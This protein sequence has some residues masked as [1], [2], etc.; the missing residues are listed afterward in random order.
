MVFVT[1]TDPFIASPPDKNV[2]VGDDMAS[3]EVNVSVIISFALARVDV[4]LLDAILTPLRVGN[5]LSNITLPEPL[6]TAEPA[7]PFISE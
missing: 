1:V 7:T 2:T 6:V 4:V 5:V 3:L